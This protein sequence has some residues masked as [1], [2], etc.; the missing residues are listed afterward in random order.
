MP[1]LS[2]CPD[3]DP[4][5][6]AQGRLTHFCVLVPT[7]QAFSLILASLLLES[8]APQHLFFSS[9]LKNKFSHEFYKQISVSYGQRAFVMI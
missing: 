8:G 9:L 3:G 5:P 7:A 2:P 4:A 1:S 6:G